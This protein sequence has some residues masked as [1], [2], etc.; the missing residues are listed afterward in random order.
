[1]EVNTVVT[2]N[3]EQ[4]RQS[5]IVLFFCI[6]RHYTKMIYFILDFKINHFGLNYYSCQIIY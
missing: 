5:L 2:N 4:L 6:I 1:M 3:I